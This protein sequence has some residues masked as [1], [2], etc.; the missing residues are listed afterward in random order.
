MSLTNCLIVDD[1]RLSRMMI[2]KF[3]LQ[4]HPDWHIEEAGTG[5]EALE[6][7]SNHNFQVITMDFNMPGMNGLDTAEQ[8]RAQFP[9]TKIALLTANVQESI[10]NRANDLGLDFIPKPITEEK[11]KAY[12]A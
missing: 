1:S 3:I 12:V 6:L 9:E 8:L 10:Q 4:T 7:A 2:Q 5:E 11:I